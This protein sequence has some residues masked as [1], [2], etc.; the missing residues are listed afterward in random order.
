MNDSVIVAELL[1]ATKWYFDQKNLSLKN[2]ISLRCQLSVENQKDIRL[3]YSQYFTGLLSATELFLEKNYQNIE[4]FKGRLELALSFDE[5]PNGPDNYSYL[6]E[7]RNSIIHRGLDV[8]SAAHVKNDFPLFVAPSPITNRSGNKTYDS[9]GFYLIEVISKC[10][11]VIGN[12]FLSH[13]EECGL[14]EVKF[15]QDKLMENLLQSITDNKV[16]PEWAK[17]MALESVESVKFE[18]IHRSNINNLK[19]TLQYNALANNNA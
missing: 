15:S 6:R 5:H 11:R 3:Y 12:V 16:M 1:S 17:K 8:T 18:E 13:F 7:L 2:A 10:E 4:K 14:F 19:E 9:F